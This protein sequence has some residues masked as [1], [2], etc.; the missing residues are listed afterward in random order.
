MKSI[1]HDINQNA[2]SI[3]IDME[4]TF[5]DVKYDDND[6]SNWNCSQGKINAVTY[7]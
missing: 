5:Y 4:S 7:V 1:K 3:Q 6:K 2:V